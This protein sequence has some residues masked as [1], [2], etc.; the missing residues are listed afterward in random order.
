V[1]ITGTASGR[2]AINLQDAPESVIRNTRVEQPG[3]D[4]GGIR[5]VRSPVTIQDTSI[6]VGRYLVFAEFHRSQTE[7]FDL[8]LGPD[9]T[10]QSPVE[11]DATTLTET[12]APSAEEITHCVSL[13]SPGGARPVALAIPRINGADLFGEVLSPED[14]AEMYS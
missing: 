10:F 6:S 8:C 7:S 1:T 2:S 9:V 13:K 12:G 5:L 14:L 11:I 3:A 4:R